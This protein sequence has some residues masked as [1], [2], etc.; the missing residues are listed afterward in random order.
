MTKPK[1]SQARGESIKSRLWALMTIATFQ[2]ARRFGLLDDMLANARSHFC[3]CYKA[4]VGPC[5]ALIPAMAVAIY[6]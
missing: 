3:L 5:R 4:E 2:A 6:P 1:L